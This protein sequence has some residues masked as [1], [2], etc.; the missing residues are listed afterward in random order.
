MQKVVYGEGGIRTPDSVNYTR[1]P[2]VLLK[3]GSDTSP[4]KGVDLY[5]VFEGMSRTIT[6]HEKDKKC[7]LINTFS[8]SLLQKIMHS[9]AKHNL[10]K[11]IFKYL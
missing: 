11:N 4:S 3:P 6:I 5:Q 10:Y 1:V 8:A 7:R 2:V 9:K